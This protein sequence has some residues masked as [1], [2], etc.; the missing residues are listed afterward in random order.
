MDGLKVTII[1]KQKAF[2]VPTGTRLLIRRCCNAVL[3]M[4]EFGK[5]AEVTVTFVDNEQIRDLNRTHRNVDAET[6]VLSFPLGENGVYDKNYETGAYMLGDVVISLE[7]ANAQAKLYGH[8]FRREIGYL[9]AHSMLHLL[10]YDHVGN[11]IEA[12][13]MRE[14][15]ECVMQSLGLSRLEGYSDPN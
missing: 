3:T 8:S 10:G 6:D 1:N 12:M 5:P 7:K 14:K 13:K 11:D 4:E 15:E 2:K 9:T